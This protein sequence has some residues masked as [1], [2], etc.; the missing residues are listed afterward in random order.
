MLEIHDPYVAY[1]F[2]EACAYILGMMRKGKKP[3]FPKP[4][5]EKNGPKGKAWTTN[6]EAMQ[7]LLKETKQG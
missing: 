7:A 4:E 2:D 3:R 5:N 1:C 6:A